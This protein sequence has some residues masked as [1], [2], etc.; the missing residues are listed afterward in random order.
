MITGI[1]ESKTLTKHISCECKCIFDGSKCNSDQRWN[2]N[3]CQ[4]KCRKRHLWKNDYS[5]NPAT[6]SCENGKYLAI[7]MDDSA[8][9]CDDV[10]ESYAKE[11]KTIPT[12]FNEKRATC[13][14]YFACIFI[15]HYSIID[16]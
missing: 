9:M 7:F 2:N 14:T 5:W 12:N 3:K 1:N 6:C 15:N 13:K 10:L 4:C 8:I 16:N 11:T